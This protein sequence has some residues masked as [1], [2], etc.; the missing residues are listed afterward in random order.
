GN[1]SPVTP[2]LCHPA[3]ALPDLATAFPH[4]APAFPQL[5]WTGVKEAQSAVLEVLRKNCGGLNP[6]PQKKLWQLLLE[7]QGSFAMTT[8]L[9]TPS[10]TTP[11][12]TTPSL[13]APSLTTPSL[14]TPSLTTPSLH[15][16]SL[17]TPSLP[18]PSLTT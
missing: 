10:L 4:P 1:C 15:T 5:P 18:T 3:P 2:S 12:L 6:K 11:S 9:H 8:S 14:H 17:P 7:F 16:P 13:H